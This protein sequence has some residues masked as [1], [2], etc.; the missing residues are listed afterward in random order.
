MVRRKQAKAWEERKTANQ[1]KNDIAAMAEK[2]KARCGAVESASEA[3][4][5]QKAQK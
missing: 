3:S 5:M 1:N 2:L 4:K